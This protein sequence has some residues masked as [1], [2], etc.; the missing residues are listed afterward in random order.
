MRRWASWALAGAALLCAA[1]GRDDVLGARSEGGA[2]GGAEVVVFAAASLTEA[3]TELGDLLE[4][5]SNLAVTFNFASSSDLAVQIAEG[6]P[7]DVYASADALQMKV[8]ADAGLAVD[9]VDFATNRL[10]IITPEDNPAGLE[11]PDD[12]ARAGVKLVLG[13]PEVPAGNYARRAFEELGLAGSIEPNV[14]SNEDDVKQVVTKVR[15][16]EADAGVCYVT[17]VTPEVESEVTTIEFPQEAG[18][19]ARYPVTVLSEAPNPD[20]ARA[21][22]DL[23]LSDDGREVLQ[24]HGFGAPQRAR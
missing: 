11:S 24:R 12:L 9:P 21:F 2:A 20:G 18:I 1:C 7:A 5:R 17:D 14:V 6:A 8:L 23:V 10:V 22:Y 3:F 15:L 13:G 19:E 4:G 16:G